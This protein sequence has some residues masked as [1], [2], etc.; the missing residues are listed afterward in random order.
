MHRRGTRLAA[1]LAAACLM[2]FGA[3]ACG[4]GDDNGGSSS[5]KSTSG[6]EGGGKEGGYDQGADRHRARLPRSGEGYTTQAAEATGSATSGLL[7]YKHASGPAGGAADPGARRGAAEDLRRRQDV[8]AQAAQGPRRTR[9]A[10]PVKASDFTHSVERVIKLNWGGKSFFTGYVKGAA[11]LRQRQGQAR[12]RASGRRRDGQDH[13]HA[14]HAVRRVPERARVPVAGPPAEAARRSRTCRTT[15]PRR[16][17]VHAHGRRSPN[18]TYSLV[19]NPKFAGVK[20]PDIPVGHLDKITFKHHVEHAD[21][22]PAGPQQPGRRRSTP[23]TRCRRRCCRRSARRP[24]TGSR[25]RPTASTYYF[26]LNTK[27]KP[28][29]NQKARQAVNCA[30]DR[31]ALSRLASGYLTPDVLLPAAR[32]SSATRPAPVPVRRPDKPP[33]SRRPSSS[34]SSPAWPARRSRSGARSAARASSTS[35]TTPSVLNKIGF[36]ATPKIIADAVYFPTIGNVKTK[37]QTGFADWIQD[38]PN[39]SDFYL[40]LDAKSDP[41]DEQPELQQRRRSEDPVVAGGAQPGAG[42][43]ARRGRQRVDGARPVP[44]EEGV[45]R[46]LR[47]PSRCRSSSRTRSTSTSAVFHPVYCNDWFDRAAEGVALA[48]R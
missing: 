30:V 11:R 32:A 48:G 33:T 43:G 39:P 21:R 16:R 4:G 34:S 28:F 22:G 31:R 19:K 46:R 45:Q 15:R 47:L 17:P 3:V 1:A 27:T 5:N 20:I 6:T 12:S 26:F 44:G 9:T 7:T 2:G 23:A 14:R 41:A 42:D 36:K 8:H 37:A 40:L 24:R 38:F 13:D 18:R 29:N 35:S 25:S 10:R